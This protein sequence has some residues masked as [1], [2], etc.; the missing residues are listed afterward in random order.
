[1]IYFMQRYWKDGWIHS[2]Q[3]VDLI[4]LPPPAMWTFGDPLPFINSKFEPVGNSKY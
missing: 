1:M 2:E 3:N 4:V